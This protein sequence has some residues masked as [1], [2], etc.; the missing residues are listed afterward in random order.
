MRFH[1]NRVITYNQF[2]GQIR[3]YEKLKLSGR[4]P[5]RTV[6]A[7]W[8]N[9]ALH[10]TAFRRVNKCDRIIITY[11]VSNWKCSAR[12]HVRAYEY[13]W[14]IEKFFRTAKQHLGL[15][16]CQSRKAILQQN[17]LLNVFSR[18]LYCNMNA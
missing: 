15:N 7:N 16:V 4:R 17:H 6:K 18:M 13:R 10:F 5:M 11:Q 14:H 2:K 3:H 12:E 9:M 1:S 8:Y